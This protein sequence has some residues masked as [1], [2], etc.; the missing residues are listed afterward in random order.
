MFIM[1]NNFL[2]I[3]YVNNNNN[4][5]KLYHIQMNSIL[6]LLLSRKTTKII[7]AK[8]LTIRL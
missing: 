5:F 2:F 8:V 4:I 3:I 1:S 6:S 7:V